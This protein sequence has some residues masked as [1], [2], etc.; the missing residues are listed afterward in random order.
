MKK[1]IQ[2]VEE[3]ERLLFKSNLKKKVV[4]AEAGIQNSIMSYMIKRGREN[5]PLNETHVQKILAAI[6]TLSQKEKAS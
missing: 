6:E 1:P 3:I 4:C 5:K 2:V